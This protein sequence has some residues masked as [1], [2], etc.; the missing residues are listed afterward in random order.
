MDDFADQHRKRLDYS[1][2]CSFAGRPILLQS[3]SAVILNYA[4]EF[5]SPRNDSAK[6]TDAAPRIT[7][8]VK[9]HPG[10]ERHDAPWF[11]GRGH[12]A[13]ARFTSA[14]TVWFNLRART[15][16]GVF[17]PEAISDSLRWRKDIFP[18]IAGILAPVVSV[19]PAHAACLATGGSG[20]L[21]AGA[22]GTGKTTLS[23]TLARLGYRFLSDE[24]T[25]LTENS[26]E[27][28]A[29]GL[30]VPVKLLPDAVNFFPELSG[31]RCANSLN[32]EFAYE[33]SPQECFTLSRAA[34]CRVK[35]IVLLER[36]AER[37]CCIEPVSAA[38]AISRLAADIEPLT[39][40]LRTAYQEQLLVLRRMSKVVCIRAL[41][42]ASPQYVA[43]ALHRA[44]GHIIDRNPPDLCSS[45]NHDPAL[46][47][48]TN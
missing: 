14:D 19:V 47:I 26:G 15:A 23:I 3:N 39:G 44:L 18:A 29:W 28:Q 43:R 33:V 24:W 27:T 40:H 35:C 37:G 30:P 48:R 36:S 12:F 45:E 2:C 22:S 21:L 6:L 13:M 9:D 5:F 46:L 10:H 42:N 20:V 41:F 25:Y 34:S 7:L 31:Y 1:Q 38:E 4:A 32:G 17:S 11:R 8:V 16:Y